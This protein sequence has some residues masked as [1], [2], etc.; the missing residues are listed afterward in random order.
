MILLNYTDRKTGQKPETLRKTG[1]LPAVFYGKKEKSTPITVSSRD[2]MK[3]W[4]QAGESGIVSL[5]TSDSTTGHAVDALIHEVTVHPLTGMPLHA[6]F[7]VFEKG[8]KLE[9][10]VPLEFDGVAPAIK[11]LGGNLVKVLH[12][13]N[14]MASPEHIPH[15]ITV[16]ISTL[17]DFDSH[18][19]ASDLVLPTGVELAGHTEAV[20]ASIA[21]PKAEETEEVVAAPD[22]SAI[23]VEKKGKKEEEAI[24]EA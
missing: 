7:Y 13:I 12:E 22:L 1:L 19:L 9:V 5:K 11:D 3:V 10:S 2:F 8:K 23:E 6:D 20:V 16:D 14:V 18:I 15:S 4:K 21:Q 24:P 17:A